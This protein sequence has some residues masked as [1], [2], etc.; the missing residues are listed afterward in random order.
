VVGGAESIAVS[1]FGFRK[2]LVVIGR[3]VSLLLCTIGLRD[4][5]S[6]GML[7]SNGTQVGMSFRQSRS[8][9]RA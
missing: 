3:A 2:A 9:L 5:L 4:G 8:H 7:F 6:F 1:G